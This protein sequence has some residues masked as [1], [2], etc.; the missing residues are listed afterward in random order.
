MF[1]IFPVCA[2]PTP[3]NG[4]VSNT[5]FSFNETITVSCSAGYTVQGSSTITCQAD[6]TWSDTAICNPNGKHITLFSHLTK[7]RYV[8]FYAVAFKMIAISLSNMNVYSCILTTMHVAR[9]VMLMLVNMQ[10]MVCFHVYL[11]EP[12]IMMQIV[13][14]L[15]LLMDWQQQLV[16]LLAALQFFPVMLDMT[17]VRTPQQLSALH[18]DGRILQLVTFKVQFIHSK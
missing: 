5:I 18:L 6:G 2:D 16:Q 7:L 9:D 12:F 13:E 10:F 4:A 8:S 1:H 14:V 17:S 11:I 15:L 3:T